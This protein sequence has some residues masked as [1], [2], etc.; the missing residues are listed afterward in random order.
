V[1][2]VDLE[3]LRIHA[4]NLDAVRE[5]FGT[6]RSA[7]RQIDQDQAALGP[8]C[9]WIFTGLGDRHTKQDELIAYAE[10]NLLLAADGIRR[11]ADGRGELT[12]LTRGSG[13]ASADSNPEPRSPSEIVSRVIE[14]VRGRD[15]VEDLLAEAAPVVEFAVPVSDSFAVLRAG[16]LDWAMAH[17][18]P[19]RQMLDDLTGMPEVV[20]S[21]AAIWHT[22]AADLH[23]I[24]ADLR[25]HLDRD[26]AG[27]DRPD[28]SA[29]L[30]MMSH[31]VEAIS[32]LA[33]VSTA[34]ALITK[35]AG[36]LILLTRDIVRG[37]IADLV[38][39]VVLWLA[40]TAV[41]PMPVTAAQLATAVATFWRI[42]AYVTALVTSMTQLSQYLDG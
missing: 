12:E 7:S 22:M 37:L 20:A 16:A 6:V 4:S 18:E 39:R 14:A 28:V 11:V 15:W 19:L 32:G 31:N 10:Q 5:R 34:M 35:A 13:T 26:L 2:P 29:Y 27:S 36:D 42:H 25:S 40:E 38:A 3:L 1:R 24:G 17:V 41:V 23:G 33:V 30:A 9:G 8:L 21:H